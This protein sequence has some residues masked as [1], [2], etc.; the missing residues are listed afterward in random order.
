MMMLMTATATEPIRIL[1][2]GD[3][4]TQGGVRGRKEYTYRWPLFKKLIDADVEFDFIGSLQKGLHPDAEWPAE[5]KG[6]PF[7]PDHEGVYGIKTAAALK[8]LP[9]AMKAWSAPPDIVLIHLGTNDQKARNYGRAVIQP[10]RQIISLIRQENPNAVFLLGHL[11]FND[12]PALAIRKLVN[13][14]AVA[15]ESD[16]SPVVT[17]P[18]YE[19][20]VADPEAPDTDTFDWAHPNP[21]GQEKMAQ[22]WFQ[23]MWA[24]VEDLRA[25]R[26]E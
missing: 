3:S 24:Y 8:R 25:A 7:D 9:E 4:I 14:L 15:M 1:P 12:G 18:M 20:W 23:H 19:N 6:I 13:A 16:E 17:V 5:Y 2:L 11:N 10:L 26:A 22:Q 21:Q